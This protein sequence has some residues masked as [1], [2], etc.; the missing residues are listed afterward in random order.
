MLR[1][2][3]FVFVLLLVWNAPVRSAEFTYVQ[4]DKQALPEFETSIYM[5]GPIVEGDAERLSVLVAQLRAAGRPFFRKAVLLLDS[6]GGAL[7]PALALTKVVVQE[8]LTTYVG[9]GR[10]CLSGCAIV[11]MA[12]TMQDGDDTRETSRLLHQRAVLGFHAPFAF[13]QAQDIPAE[14]VQLLLKDAERG[15]SIAA[16]KLVRLSLSGI[17]PASLVEELLQYESGSFLYI[18]T[19]DR[20]ARWG[21]ALQGSGD[22]KL[23]GGIVQPEDWRSLS[24]HCNNWQH[25]TGDVA[26]EN[27]EVVHSLPE[28]E[29]SYDGMDDNCGYTPFGNK[30]DFDVNGRRGTVE[31]WQTLPGDTK[32]AAIPQDA[33]N[34]TLQAVDPFSAP[35]PQQVNGPCVG[36]FQWLGGWA[37][38]SYQNSV[39]YAIF[40]PCGSVGAPLSLI[41]RHGTGQIET[42]LVL[43]SFGVNGAGAARVTFQ[44]DDEAEGNFGGQIVDNA[45]QRE[46]VFSLVRHYFTFERMMAGQQMIIKVNDRAH[47]IHLTGAREAIQAMKTACI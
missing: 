10:K 24:A 28:N 43:A 40:Q 13:D 42:H 19:V 6:P 44:I 35:P 37:G 47:A 39:A 32:L 41:C 5:T 31:R 33:L 20:A 15:G 8:G 30:V 26:F 34:G 12:G 16:S 17:L 27:R 3:L 4:N 1:I 7:D 29:L 22:Y 2:S 45:G 36:G 21:I 23:H 46:Y 11:F 25:W 14:V 38:S 18:D 9:D